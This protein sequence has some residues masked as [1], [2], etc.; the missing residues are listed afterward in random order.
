MSALK[1]TYRNR[2]SDLHEQWDDGTL[3][4]RFRAA[5]MKVAGTA[6]VEDSQV[7]LDAKLPLAAIVF[8]NMIKAR[9]DKE[10]A[11]LLA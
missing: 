10:L 4:F 3:S 6:T 7:K 1:D 9:V 11:S 2:F 8:K 5:G